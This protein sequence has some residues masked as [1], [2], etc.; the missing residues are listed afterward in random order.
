MRRPGIVVA[1]AAVAALT[2]G[3]LSPSGA[4]AEHAPAGHHGTAARPADVPPPP[5]GWDTVFADDFTGA[6]GSKLDG[7]N[8]L[9]DTG[10]GYPGGADHWG[11]GEVETMTDSTD[12]VYQDGNGHLVIKPT[13]NG[14]AWTS[15]RVETQRTDLGAPA[16]GQLQVT[17]SIRQPDPANGLGYWP[18][19]W[20]LGADA[21][22][23]GGTNWPG[24]GE[25]DIL[26]DV[27]ALSKTDGTVHCGVNPG[28]P[29]NETNGL[30]S[31]LLD[32]G[33]CQTDF[34]TYSVVIDR[35][36]TSNEQI[37]WYLDGQQ[38]FAVSES[39]MDATTWQNAF[40]HGF[41][42]ILNVA[43]GGG[44]PNGVCGCASPGAD[45][46]SGADMSV[47]YV[48]AYQTK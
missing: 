7:T 34:H 44:F 41:F 11:T 9:Y 4:S 20:M 15:G 12:N 31:G 19:F 17:A 21:R 16:G 48:A 3:A 6:A 42:V 24:V 27:N 47:D 8:W 26:E 45:T 14:G 40:D 18:A 29:C 35:T 30:G 36:D 1:A 38:T 32:C 39:Q 2:L 23:V 46:T 37:R 43:M 25:I 5:S 33:G 13:S 10:T 28:G 22:P